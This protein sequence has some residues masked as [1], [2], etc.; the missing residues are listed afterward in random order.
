MIVQNLQFFDKF[1]ENL[2]LEFDNELSAWVGTIYFEPI[3]A[4]VFEN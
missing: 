1:G 3:S 2:N 4:S